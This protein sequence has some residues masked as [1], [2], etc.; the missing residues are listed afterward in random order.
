[1]NWRVYTVKVVLIVLFFEKKNYC[2]YVLDLDL[3]LYGW[4][5]CWEVCCCFSLHPSSAHETLGIEKSAICE[6]VPQ[7]QSVFN[8]WAPLPYCTKV[9]R[10]VSHLPCFYYSLIA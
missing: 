9:N 8:C 6:W 4:C 2:E 7:L 3:S 10:T 1:M 5:F